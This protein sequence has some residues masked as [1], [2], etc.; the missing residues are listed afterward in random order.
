MCYDNYNLS[1]STASINN[2]VYINLIQIAYTYTYTQLVAIFVSGD[3]AYLCVQLA[4]FTIVYIIQPSPPLT[5]SRY[6]HQHAS[7]SNPLTL[8]PPPIDFVVLAYMYRYHKQ[9]GC[10]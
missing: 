9:V 6:H 2:C 8:Y 3:E 1:I 10:T 5:H 7:P 4:S